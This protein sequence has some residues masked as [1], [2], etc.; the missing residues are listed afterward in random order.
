MRDEIFGPVLP[1]VP[2]ETLD[3]AVAFVNGRDKPLAL[4]CLTHDRAS[5]TLVLD[6][7]T[8]GGVT[9]NGL[10]LH[11]VQEDLPFGG[12]GSSGMGAYHGRTGFQRLSH[13]RSVHQVRFVNLLHFT[14]PPYGRFVRLVIRGLGSRRAS[15][16]C[17]L[18]DGRV[19]EPQSRS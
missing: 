15:A 8:S 1:I 18:S 19:R 7:T 17:R 6:R 16:A 14:A 4:Y 11:Q 5:R 2:Y 10:L 12:V 3:E 9:I 13:A